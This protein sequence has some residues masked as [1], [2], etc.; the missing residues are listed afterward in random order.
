MSALKVEK[1]ADIVQSKGFES[2]GKYWW[3][4]EAGHQGRAGMSFCFLIKIQ[5]KS[6]V[7]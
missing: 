1:I 5:D 7:R 6:L 2:V 3:G 4:P